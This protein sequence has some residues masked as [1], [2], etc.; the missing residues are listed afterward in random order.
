MQVRTRSMK[1]TVDLR[2]DLERAVER[3]EFGLEYQPIIDLQN[4]SIAA[5]EALLR[6]RHPLLGTIPPAEYLPLAE[7]TGLIVPIGQRVLETA[8]RQLRTWHLGFARMQGLG[9]NINV[10]PQQLARSDFAHNV[11]VALDAAEVSPLSLTLELSPGCADYPEAAMMLRDLGVLLAIEDFG[12]GSTLEDIRRLPVTALKLH[13]SFV[14]LAA[15]PPEDVSFAES[16]LAIARARSLTTTGKGVETRDQA[17]RL[18]ALGCDLAQGFLYSKP[19]GPEGIGT[20]LARGR[21]SF[22]GMPRLVR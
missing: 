9:M 10:A 22:T 12:A 20:L 15:G 6:W 7:E 14:S 18:A 2:Q 3:N 5:V 17:R 16:L 1:P 19:L 4:G 11:E 21:V 13:A 8:T